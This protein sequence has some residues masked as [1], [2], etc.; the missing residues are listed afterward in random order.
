M[1]RERRVKAQIAVRNLSRFY[2][3]HQEGPGFQHPIKAGE[4][5]RA[6]CEQASQSRQSFFMILFADT[7]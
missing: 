6:L 7:L 3:V 5:S 1:K 4:L 2:Q